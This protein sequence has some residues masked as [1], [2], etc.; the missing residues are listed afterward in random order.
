[1][2]INNKIISREIQGEMVLLNMENGDYFSLNSLGTEIYECISNGMQN[3]EIISF[4]L[5]KYDVGA[6]VLKND[7]EA[8][9]SRMMEKNILIKI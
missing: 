8:L 5:N 3:E 9:I 7:F 6:D 1:M 4:L 2:K